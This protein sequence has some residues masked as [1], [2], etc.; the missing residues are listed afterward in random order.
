MNPEYRE[1]SDRLPKCIICD[2]V[3]TPDQMSIEHIIPDALGGMVEI[4]T[5][6]KTC[7][8]EMGRSVDALLVDDP[9]F[10]ILRSKFGIKTKKGKCVDIT[11]RLE[12]ETL[13]GEKA[14]I[15]DG[16][17]IHMPFRYDGTKKPE[18]ELYH[19]QGVD[20]VRVS[21][22]DLESIK[23][24]A[25][26]TLRTKGLSIPDDVIDRII[27]ENIKIEWD[28]SMLRTSIY[29]NTND[30]SPCVL[31]IAYEIMCTL[32]PEEYSTDERG[33][34]IR[35]FLLSLVNNTYNDNFDTCICGGIDRDL[36]S[37]A[38]LAGFLK[39][40]NNQLYI[41]L[42]LFGG[43]NFKILI[44]NDSDKYNVDCFEGKNII[45]L[46]MNRDIPL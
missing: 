33:N 13:D 38:F 42:A 15:K 31:K 26:K 40:D 19:D 12:Y 21:G 16:D 44:S 18:V 3:I 4:H 34:R 27:D 9:L 37:N 29:F 36:I 8:S 17:G 35:S 28:Y 10:V 39:E 24:K 43:I 6:C 22:S 32:F 20:K 41:V 45:Q 25:K 11:H 14:V 7:N 1:I 30:Y 5:V 2:N 46:L 23:K